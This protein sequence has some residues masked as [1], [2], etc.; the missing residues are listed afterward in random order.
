MKNIKQLTTAFGLFGLVYLASAS[1][2]PVAAL[3]GSDVVLGVTT[4]HVPV[5]AGIADVLPQVALA[6]TAITGMISTVVLLKKTK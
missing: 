6:S 4:P 5:P 1:V 3:Y 2:S